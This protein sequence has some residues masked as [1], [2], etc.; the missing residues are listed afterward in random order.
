MSTPTR[1]E[2]LDHLRVHYGLTLSQTMDIVNIPL[3]P[4]DMRDDFAKAALTGLTAKFG[5]ID[6]AKRAYE[7]ADAM[8]KE[9]IK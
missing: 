6:T 1:K 5:S 4:F 9:R 3:H 7:I 2:M 8:L